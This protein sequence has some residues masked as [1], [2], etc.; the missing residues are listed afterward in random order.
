M[1]N[2]RLQMVLTMKWLIVMMRLM[3][4][5]TGTHMKV[6][7]IDVMLYFIYFASVSKYIFFYLC[8]FAY[9]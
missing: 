4:W 6:I 2:L 7:L 5:L 9:S 1:T 3:I 8:L